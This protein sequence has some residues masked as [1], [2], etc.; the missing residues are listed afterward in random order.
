MSERDFSAIVMKGL[1]FSYDG[2]PVLED[3]NL[4]IAQ[5]DFVSVV[6]PNGGGKTTLL[7][8]ML[9]LLRPS[10]G[11]VSVF[12]ATPEAARPRIGYMPQHSQL[13]PQFPATVMDVALMG[14]LGHG[15]FFG[16]H[17]RKD[18]EAAIKALD[19][20]GLQ[21]L[22][23]MPFASISGG[24]RQRLF[25]ARALAC[26]PEILLLDEPMAN[27]DVVMEGDLYNLLQRFNEQLTIVMVSH[28]LGFVSKIVKNVICVNRRVAMHATSE[29]TGKIIDEIYGSPM[30]MVRHNGEGGCRC[31][32]S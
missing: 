9:G 25:I 10:R 13:D 19:E 16:W 28:D 32:S 15:R 21:D 2:Q 17:S 27:L 18:K 3:V 22:R 12:G 31:P 14:R 6:G 20:V 1:S 26:E 7:K 30:R 5:G 4:A 8:L 11:E 23:K 24:Q 29:I